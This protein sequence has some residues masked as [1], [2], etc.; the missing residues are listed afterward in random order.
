ML[1]T[2]LPGISS[3]ILFLFS[4]IFTFIFS[5]CSDNE[6]VVPETPTPN[7]FGLIVDSLIEVDGIIE[8]N[9]TL[10]DILT[11]HGIAKNKVHEIALAAEPVF[12]TRNFK[13]GNDFVVYAT[14][15]TVETVKYFVYIADPVNYVVFDLRDSIKVYKAQKEVVIKQDSAKATING[16]LYGTFEKL[17]LDPNL[18]VKMAEVYAWQIDFYRIQVGDHFNVY[19]EQAFVEG[20]P[21]GVGKILAAKFNHNKHDFYAIRFEQDKNHGYYDEKGNSARKAFLKS[22]LKF[23]RITSRFTNKRFH[24]VLKRMKAHLGTD[25]AAPTGTPILSVGDG[26]VVEAHYKVF[27]GNYVKIKHNA[28][29]TTQYL[30]MSKIA[31]GM[32]PGKHVTQGQVIGFVGSTGLAT[33]PHVCFRF[34]KNGTQVDPLKEKIPAS[35]PVKPELKNEYFSLLNSWLPRLNS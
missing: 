6:K 31:P 12:S 7:S 1:R 20:K 19:Y 24:P 35:D 4:M 26:T 8:P 33:G 14:W 27:N 18:A 16:S 9:Q 34:W 11:T 3:Q 5:S 30:H 32:K 21:Y 25:Y 28:T 2:N 13:A 15:D 23:S 10:S 22:P 29:Y 17:N